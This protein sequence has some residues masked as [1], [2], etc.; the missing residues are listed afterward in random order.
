MEIL[1]KILDR[2]GIRSRHEIVMTVAVVSNHL[3]M[4]KVLQKGDD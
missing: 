1:A 4:T 3:F 2:T